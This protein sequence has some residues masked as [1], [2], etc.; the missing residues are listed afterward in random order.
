MRGEIGLVLLCLLA[1]LGGCWD[2]QEPDG[3]ALVLGMGVDVD[4]ETGM[5]RVI[6]Q[7]A[8]P[9][10]LGT[11]GAEEGGGG[12]SSPPAKIIS[13]RGSTLFEAARNMEAHTTRTM[14]W[15]HTDVIL[16]SESAA[17]QGIG[18]ILDFMEREQEV[19]LM[20]RPLVVEG[21][22]RELL[23]QNFPLEEIPALAIFRQTEALQV[24]R[25]IIPRA[26][27]L[28]LL[29]MMAAPGMDPL[30]PRIQLSQEAARQREED[31]QQEADVDQP[32]PA[33]LL[34][35]AAFQGDRM[36]GWLTGSQARGCNWL[37]SHVNR[38][39]LLVPF[40][41]EEIAF[42]VEVFSARGRVEPVITD[43]QIRMKA[44][45]D[46]DARLQD[47]I[48][49]A[50]YEEETEFTRR[51]SSEVAQVVR[52]DIEA[53]LFRAQELGADVFGFGNTIYR[54]HPQLWAEIE[55]D[56]REIFSQLTLELEV[57]AE[58]RRPGH[59]LSPARPQ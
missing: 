1:L 3:V 4:P 37:H 5:Y 22:V 51:L 26:D 6:A 59:I 58:I 21:D 31:D 35:A 23:S 15:A 30:I 36:V 49:Q 56:W 44:R 50:V 7:I 46:L 54:K 42:T 24:S 13:A 48:F 40:P 8:N 14:S 27:F 57:R 52:D 29:Q 17:R 12:G 16:L 45:V 20:A 18:P 33:E 9:L 11:T 28:Q 34:G 2:R 55:D 39:T 32:S 47:Q 41:A 43:G 10:G 38:A 25:S 53:A 19:R